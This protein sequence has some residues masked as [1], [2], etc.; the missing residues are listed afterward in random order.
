MQD[1]SVKIIFKSWVQLERAL[2]TYTVFPRCILMQCKEAFELDE[3]CSLCIDLL[4]KKVEN[5][6]IRQVSEERLYSG[7]SDF[8]F[9]AETPLTIINYPERFMEESGWDACV[10]DNMICLTTE[11]PAPFY[12]KIQASLLHI[13]IPE[14][15]PWEKRGA[16]EEWI[17]WRCRREKRNIQ[18]EAVQFLAKEFGSDRFVLRQELEK[19]FVYSLEREVITV[20]DLEVVIP[21]SPQGTVWQLC[22]AIFVR[23]AQAVV[24]VLRGIQESE[25]HVFQTLRGLR[26]QMQSALRLVSMHAGGMSR[27]EIRATMPQLRGKLFD[28]HFDL[29]L[30]YGLE[31]CKKAL[32]AIDATEVELKNSSQDEE[33]TL[34]RL[35][36]KATLVIVN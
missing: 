32:I 6:V 22:D 14:P 18:P 28:R 21:A 15:K 31:A 10:R 7:G 26:S 19:L 9:F 1:N 24:R 13:D 11:L 20:A 29:A 34:E 30:Q 36:L 5:L 17:V 12:K 8:A 27:E 4:R 23:D 25:F 2:S 16:I 33:L 3:C 35:A